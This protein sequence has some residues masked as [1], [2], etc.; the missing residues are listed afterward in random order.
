MKK[1]DL[2]LN[3]ELTELV[4]EVDTLG[5]ETKTLALNLALYLAK[6]KAGGG[7]GR[8][9][10]LEPEFIKLVN[11][12]VSV[13]QELT[14]ILNAAQDKEKMVYQLP[15]GRLAKDHIEHKMELIVLQCNRILSS[16]TE[17]KDLI[18]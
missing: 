14:V 3:A 8:L 17:A 16:L 5:T 15:S 12:T 10:M 13:I 11:G 1:T 6:A 4:A 7:S 9:K 2:K 18:A